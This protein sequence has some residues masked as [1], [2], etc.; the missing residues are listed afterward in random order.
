MKIKNVI[1]IPEHRDFLDRKI[2]VGDIV[3]VVI[4]NSFRLAKVQRMTPK[5]IRVQLWYTSGF[6]TCT[7]VRYPH[8]MMVANNEYVTMYMIKHSKA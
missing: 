8:E 2:K 6:D 7:T 5:M 1:H 3:V 4:H